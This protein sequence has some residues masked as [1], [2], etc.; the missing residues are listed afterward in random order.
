[1][2]TKLHA[3]C[4]SQG[5]PLNLFVTAGHPFRDI[6]VQYPFGQWSA[7]TSVHGRSSAA[8]QKWVG[9]SATTGMT[10]IGSEK[11]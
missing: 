11:R 3:I 4:D 9:Y 5:S 7:T 1:M 10:P 6:A 8:Y 2:N